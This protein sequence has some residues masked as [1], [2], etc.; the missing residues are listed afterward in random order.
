MN[1][2]VI[3]IIFRRALTP[4]SPQTSS[5]AFIKMI[6]DQAVK[7]P[8]N[9]VKKQFDFLALKDLTTSVN[10]LIIA[11]DSKVVDQDTRKKLVTAT[12][13]LSSS[14]QE[15]TILIKDLLVSTTLTLSCKEEK[16][17]V[18]D[19]ALEVLGQVR[20]EGEVTVMVE[21]RIEGPKGEV[22]GARRNIR[23]FLK[24]S[25]SDK[26]V[27][28]IE[29][30][31]NQVNSNSN[32]NWDMVF[33]GV[34]LREDTIVRSKGKI[35]MTLTR[36]E[37][38]L[39][40]EKKPAN[41]IKLIIIKTGATIIVNGEKNDEF[42]KVILSGSD[43]RI[44]KVEEEIKLQVKDRI[45]VASMTKDKVGTLM[46]VGGRTIKCIEK[47]C[48]GAVIHVEGFHN[49][50]RKVFIRGS[51]DAIA[52]AQTQVARVLH[53]RAPTR[54]SGRNR[55]MEK[56][57]VQKVREDEEETKVSVKCFQKYE[58]KKDMK[59]LVASK[60][61]E[62]NL[63]GGL[64]FSGVQLDKHQATRQSGK[65]LLRLSRMEVG[66][67]VSNKGKVINTI[68][69]KSGAGIHLTKKVGDETNVIMIAGSE[70]EVLKAEKELVS[71]FREG[72][73]QATVTTEEVKI[74]DGQT[75]SLIMKKTET[76][77]RIRKTG[78]IGKLFI[79]GSKDAISKAKIEVANSLN[80]TQKDD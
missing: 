28:L 35:S 61:I 56:V 9:G 22:E 39:I 66:L 50:N 72:I 15:L 41:A 19:A 31:N 53:L 57:V 17:L 20:K 43:E 40:K 12:T 54:F 60:D 52:K 71:A 1:I 37:A 51:K 59:V 44:K 42:R 26:N 21:V 48:R 32:S 13:D 49:E 78:G 5:M 36:E 4:Y 63:K 69:K 70:M 23:S 8:I 18:S 73:V 38:D 58:N 77:I 6:E 7:K 47:K 79:R 14:M 65:V 27:A 80:W 3:L 45:V 76:I 30:V 16:I 75:L 25:T 10:D 24:E 46:G 33:T 67:L 64:T 34:K 68:R 62:N 55:E 74:L 11:I 2:L 29:V